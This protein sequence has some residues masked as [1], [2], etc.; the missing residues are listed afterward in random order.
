MATEVIMPKAGMAMERGTVLQWYRKPGEYIEAGDVLLEIE[1]DKVAMEVEAEVSGYLLKILH[2]P[3]D[4]VPVTTPIAYIGEEGESVPQDAQ[5]SGN[6]A[7]AGTGAGPGSSREQPQERQGRVPAPPQNDDSRGKRVRATPA[8][9]R[10]AGE[11]GVDLALVE[12]SGPQGEVRAAD[13]A[14]PSR[15]RR[16]SPLAEVVA[17]QEGVDLSGVAGSGPSGRI[18]REDV[19]AARVR[20]PSGTMSSMRRAIARR[21]VESHQTVPPVTLNRPVDVTSLMEV[22]R[23]LKDQVNTRISVGDFVVRAAAQALRAADYMRRFFQNDGI[24]HTDDIHIGIAVALPDGLLV[25]V[26][27]HA[28]TLSL[29]ELAARTRDLAERARNGTITPDDLAGGTFTVTNLG[30]YGISSFTPIINPPQSAILGVN[31]VEDQLYLHNGEVRTRSMMTL[32]L[33]ID[34]RVI[35]GAQGA[36]FLQDIGRYLAAP[37]GVLAG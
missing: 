11:L 15:G 9:R 28:D 35:D 33:T 6:G 23:Q 21:M 12:P 22:R 19:L 34:H 31:A 37:L 2:H 17:Q 3:G 30:M 29:V 8:A 20:Q 36:L 10:R 4:E 32:S 7:G 27:R 25:P 26:V 1:T 13:V 14:P 24:I 5:A 18:T 16:I